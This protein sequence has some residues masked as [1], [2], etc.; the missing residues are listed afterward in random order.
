MPNKGLKFLE[1]W[2]VLHSSGLQGSLTGTLFQS[3][4]NMCMFYG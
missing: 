1:I 4:Q 2:K 3:S